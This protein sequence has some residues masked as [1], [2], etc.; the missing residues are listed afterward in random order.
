MIGGDKMK[1]IVIIA[2]TILILA[3]A[4]NI[5]KA[6]H[7]SNYE[8]ITMTKGKLL[9]DY[10]SSDFKTYN[11]KVTKRKFK[12]WRTH[13]VNNRIK[14]SYITETL[15]SYYNDGY[16]PIDYQYKLDEQVTKKFNYSATGSISLK[17]N[18]TKTGFKGGLD[19]SLKMSTSY[20]KNSTKKESYEVKLKVDPGTRV[21]L[22]T[23][24]EGRVTNGVAAKYLFW[25]RSNL[26]G[27]EYFEVT[28]QYQRLEKVRI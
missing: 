22:Y 14:V 3:F 23:Y 7:Y 15:F 5:S 11:K 1:K 10:T 13:T 9:E 19:S 18:K 21:D 2:L 16:T 4:S 28:T 27:F 8:S 25:F 12:G 26:G 20:D 24:G 17:V 6:S